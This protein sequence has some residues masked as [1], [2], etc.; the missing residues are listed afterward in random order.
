[1]AM[2][3]DSLAMSSSIASGESTLGVEAKS[4]ENW[5]GLLGTSYSGCVEATVTLFV[6]TEKIGE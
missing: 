1:M 6:K 2:A 3:E 4:L 5:L